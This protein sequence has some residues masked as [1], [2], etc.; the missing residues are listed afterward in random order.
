M[1]G[2]TPRM[3]IILVNLPFEKY[4]VVQM[5][6]TLDFDSF[7]AETNGSANKFN[8]IHD[9]EQER[10]NNWNHDHLQ[11]NLGVS[12]LVVYSVYTV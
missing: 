10:G 7:Q 3:A 12:E 8:C 5:F 4:F 2:Y 9:G 1:D 6:D 11:T